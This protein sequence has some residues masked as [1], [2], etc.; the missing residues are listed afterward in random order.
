[1]P[2]RVLRMLAYT[3]AAVGLTYGGLCALVYQYQDK[4]TYFPAA[5]VS[6]NPGDYQLDYKSFELDQGQSTVTGWV[7]R[8]QEASP[9]VL[10]FH[11]NGG[12]I[13][14]RIGHL[15]LLH[16][17]GF[18]AVVFDYRGYGKS[19]GKPSEPGLLEDANA[20]RNYLLNDLG[21]P[22]E[23]LVYFG[24]S[25]GGGV[26]CALAEQHPPVGLILKSTFSSI[27]DVGAEAYPFLPVRVL[28]TNR[29]ESVKRVPNFKFP[30]L[31]LHSQADEIVPYKFGRRLFEAACEPKQW[32]EIGGTH[33]TGPLELGDDFATALEDFVY[34]ACGGR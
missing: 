19:R 31:H 28:A 14:G 22:Q 34:T 32:I 8:H 4:L 11:G 5:R 3:L 29:F 27:P 10:H 13:A 1:M 21:A 33:N 18:N 24:E 30:K 2:K 16:R 17:L 9:W 15:Q 7:V 25:L 23:K 12:N 26:A 20:V 6:V